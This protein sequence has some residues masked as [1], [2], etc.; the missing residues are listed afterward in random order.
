MATN[1]LLALQARPSTIGAQ[2]NQFA[3]N[4]IEAKDRERRQT[5]EDAVFEQQKAVLQDAT[6]ARSAREAAQ[7][8]VRLRAHVADGD[9]EG[10]RRL[11]T[12]HKQSIGGRMAEGEPVNTVETDEML[13][14]LDAD[15][16][17]LQA[18]LDREVQLAERFGL[19]S[20]VP[21]GEA[22]TLAPGAR[23]FDARGNLIAESPKET[24]YNQ[25]V[26]P[27]PD[28]KPMVNPLWLRA[29][30]ATR[31][32]GTTVRVD[33]G[34]NQ[35]EFFKTLGKKEADAFSSMIEIGNAASRNL[36]RLDQLDALLADVPTGAMA[37][38][39]RIAGNFG[40]R[41]E[42]LDDIQA[43]TALINSMVPDQRPPGTGPMSDADLALF[44]EGL[45]RIINTPGGNERIIETMRDINAY[46]RK[47]GEIS[48]AAA[49]GQISRTEARKKINALGNPL[50]GFIATTHKGR[51]DQGGQDRQPPSVTTFSDGA[52]ATN[53]QTG[54]RLQL[55]GGQW[56]PM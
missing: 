33:L 23:R 29:K 25:M 35:D 41:T 14:Q 51:E 2:V 32:P 27:G 56:V 31:A 40:I 22:F 17:A 45:P 24:D 11:L 49:D 7:L 6:K 26:I 9:V 42:G 47:I 48:A 55:R 36:Q 37:N 13:A 16:Q 30:N 19:I 43:A 1:P 20:P 39:K 38:I 5:R 46:D 52:I 10:A 12:Q 15:P 50:E 53:P 8:A 21:G 18:N 4:M 28:G 34:A 54:E 44:I 3:D